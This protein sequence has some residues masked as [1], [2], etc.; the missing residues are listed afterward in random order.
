MES[1]SLPTEEATGQEFHLPHKPVIRISAQS[2]KIRVVYDKSAKAS[3]NVPSLNECL[4]P[5]PPLQNRLWDVLIRQR[6][7][8]VALGISK[9]PS[10]KF[11][12]NN[13]NAMLSASIGRVKNTLTQMFTGS[14]EL[15][16][17]RHHSSLGKGNST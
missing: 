5:G 1:W 10:S 8:P 9:R 12:S 11:E 17:G 4:Y 7:F 14:P 13:R 3:P 2:T 15:C 16:L 6:S